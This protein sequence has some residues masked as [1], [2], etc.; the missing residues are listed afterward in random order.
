[1]ELINY[2]TKKNLCDSFT[3][4]I[5]LSDDSTTEY[6]FDWN[7]LEDKPYKVYFV[8]I[9]K[10][11]VMGIGH[12]AGQYIQ[13]NLFDGV[14]SNHNQEIN[15]IM[16]QTIN[17]PITGWGQFNI[18][19]YVKRPDDSNAALYLSRRSKVQTP[20]YILG[21]PRNQKFNVS[22]MTCF[23]NDNP[24]DQVGTRWDGITSTLQ[25]KFVGVDD[26]YK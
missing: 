2:K 23:N 10:N 18:I 5:N 16:G 26:I 20:I 7:I 1:M 19:P 8:W 15:K 21:R 3:I 9:A 11:T 4:N 25:L 17:S 22:F 6:Y 24:F 12:V 13:S 14:Y